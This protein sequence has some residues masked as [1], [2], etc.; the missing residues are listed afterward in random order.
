MRGWDTITT[1]G[2]FSPGDLAVY[3]EVDALLPVEDPRFRFLSTR[4][5]ART[6]AEGRT[7]YVLRTIR[8]R[9]EVSQGLLLPLSDF[10]EAGPDPAPGT[11]LT[12]PL[13]LRTYQ[14]PVPAHLS[15]EVK[16]PRPSFVPRTDEERVQNVP[17][18]LLPGL[19]SPNGEQVFWAPTEKI[20]GTS[21]SFFLHPKE[22]FGV[23]SRNLELLETERNTLWRVARS[24]GL[25]AL[26]RDVSPG[27]ALPVVLQGE[28]FG[29]G[30]QG[31]PLRL[32]G[33]HFRAF[34]LVI[35]TQT[36]PRLD[37]PDAV[38]AL[39]VPVHN[40]PFPSS[41]DQALEQVSG[42]RSRIS[43][44]RPAEGLVWRGSN[45]VHVQHP[46]PSY[47]RVRA[48]FKVIS[49]DYLLSHEQ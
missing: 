27:Q 45:H 39:S 19:R 5:T 41:V 38:Y 42:L 47:G 34:N 31:N 7:G 22:G 46:D 24:L 6:D 13:Q 29:E 40:L 21:A 14:P 2:Q 12:G 1:K 10:P 25:P 36:V 9:G 49:N 30:V 11:D 44:N 17:H 35:N 8:L 4:A 32:R 16:G 15:G 48:S 43:P 28:V 3:L 20:D 23:C 37:W 18:L 26:L 33:Q